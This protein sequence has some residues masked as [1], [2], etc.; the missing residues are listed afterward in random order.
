MSSTST[1]YDDE[2]A[3][4]L[5]AAMQDSRRLQT[6]DIAEWHR[7]HPHLNSDDLTLLDLLIELTQAVEVWQHSDGDPEADRDE[8]GD[9]TLLMQKNGGRIGRYRLI[10]HVGS[11]SMGDVYEAHDPQLDRRVAVKVPRCDRLARNRGMFTERFLREARSAAAVRHANICPIY[12][13]GDS[14]GQVYV[15]MAFVEGES[16][17]SVLSR[18]RINDI[19]KAVL[20]AVQ[21]ADALSAIHQHGI[22]HRDLKPGNILIDNSGQALL[23]DFG[24]ALSEMNP[25][26][27]TSDGLIIGTPVYMP[28]EQA[29]GENS[30]LSAAADIYSLGAV[31]YEMLTGQAPF[32]APLPELLRKI[33]LQTPLSPNELRPEIDPA[34]SAIVVKALA[35]LP[36]D[37]FSSAAG[38]AEALREWLGSMTS[39]VASPPHITSE[40]AR[41]NNSWLVVPAASICALSLMALV[42]MWNPEAETTGDNALEESATAM[43][44]TDGGINPEQWSHQQPGTPSITPATPAALSGKLNITVSGS[45][46]IGRITKTRVPATEPEALP[47]QTG[48]FVRFEVQLNQPAY[49]YLLWVCP[50]GNTVPIYPWDSERFAGWDAPL[51]V[52]SDRITDHILCPLNPDEGFEIV[53]PAGI[54]TVVL[55]ARRTPLDE[56]V[57]LAQVLNGLPATP[58]LAMNET[59]GPLLRGLKTGQTKSTEDPQYD[60]LKSR[61]SPH[62]EFMRVMSFPQVSASSGSDAGSEDTK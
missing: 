34:L 61:L 1:E 3:A 47:V 4:L 44:R 41:S 58:M 40:T 30:K 19:R 2:L 11:G 12:D 43:S 46:A 38:F 21:V 7:A 29:A 16:L 37:R 35:K 53:E 45:P 25:E 17:E 6:F 36:A 24:L 26:R 15:V 50:D 59:P 9:A 49:V 54:Q 57:D 32:R 5:D 18:S 55:L 56:N 62:F 33:M 51:V 20:V 27:I 10:R 42:L 28:P 60:E 39:E 52:N 14:E 13:A 23:T 8:S 22:I 31:L 48:E